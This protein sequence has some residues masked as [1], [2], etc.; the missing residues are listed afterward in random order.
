MT[1][2]TH[3]S[4]PLLPRPVGCR[5]HTRKASACRMRCSNLFPHVLASSVVFCLCLRGF[6]SRRTC[7]SSTVVHG[8]SSGRPHERRDIRLEARPARI[9]LGET[10]LLGCILFSREY[11]IGF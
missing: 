6:R 7:A 8:T 3:R 11:W 5:G 1:P 2:P 4:V 10:H 9:R